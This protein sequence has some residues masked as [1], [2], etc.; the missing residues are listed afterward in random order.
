[1]YFVSKPLRKTAGGS[2]EGGPA[3]RLR[4]RFASRVLPGGWILDDGCGTGVN[5]ES[6]TRESRHIVAIDPDVEAILN[7]RKKPSS[8]SIE[9]LP[10]QT[11]NLPFKDAAFDGAVSLEVVEH[12]LDPMLYIAE[13]ARVLRYGGTLVLSTPNRRAIQPFYI[14]GR[15]PVNI[16]HVK[17]FLPEEIK[18][19][20]EYAFQVE[21]VLAVHSTDLPKRASVLSYQKSC[22]I[23]YEIRARVPLRLRRLWLSSKGMNPDDS[24]ELEE[25]QWQT[26][27]ASRSLRYED[28]LFVASRKRQ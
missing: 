11:T 26:L 10:K 12:I 17:E 8:K 1:M 24:W 21:K 25:A 23:P 7:R 14:D 16:T 5:T 2:G 13:L 6:L 19:L 3:D 22:F 9:Y 28:L 27:M 15:S 18:S 4:Y 20:L